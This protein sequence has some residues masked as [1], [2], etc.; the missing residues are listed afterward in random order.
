MKN[1]IIPVDFSQKSEF[2]L[3]AGAFLA[4]KHNSTL[5]VVHTLEL[6]ENIFFNSENEKKVQFMI[7][8]AYKQFEPFLEKE[9]LKNIKVI[10]MIKH[11]KVYKE[12]ANVGKEIK[13]DLIIMGSHGVTARKGIFAGSNTQR[14]IHN[15]EI[16]VLIISTDPKEFQLKKVII[17]T[18]LTPESRSSFLQKTVLFTNLGCTVCPVYVN[19]PYD[20]FISSREFHKKVS[21]FAAAGNSTKVAFIAGH[22]LEDGLIQYAEDMNADLIAVNASSKKGLSYY[23]NSSIS[24]DL[25]I[26]ANLPIMT[27]TV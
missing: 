1:I 13:A 20:N 2:A 5:Y 12:V 24:E 7:A 6:S 17:A 19:L 10:T 4:K 21:V 22:T 25:S 23:W 15:S 8:Y 9:Y 3:K 18:D 16:P 14:M 27:F 11:H 26:Y